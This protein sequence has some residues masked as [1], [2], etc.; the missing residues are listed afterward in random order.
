MSRLSGAYYYVCIYRGYFSSYSGT[1]GDSLSSHNGYRFSTY[2]LDNDNSGS[3][4]ASTYHGAWWYTA[5]HSSNLNGMYI[6]G[7]S[8]SEYAKG[9]VWYHLHGHNY[10][11]MITEMK[12]RG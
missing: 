11:L 5:C 4:C 6:N 8:T 7:G 12:I 1:A 3:N 9:A 2:D 10:A